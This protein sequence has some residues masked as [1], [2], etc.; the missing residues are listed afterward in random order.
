MSMMIPSTA[1]QMNREMA[2]LP[3]KRNEDNGAWIARAAKAMK[4]AESFVLLMGGVDARAV[5]L[6]VAQARGRAD[7]TPSHFSHVAVLPGHPHAGQPGRTRLYEVPLPGGRALDDAPANNALQMGRLAPYADP[8]AYPNLALIGVP[9]TKAALAKVAARVRMG[10]PH[11]DLCEL[12]LE[13]LAFLWGVGR[14]SNPLLDGK[15]IPSAVA[16]ELLLEHAGVALT[17]N[18]ASQAS[19]PEAIWQAVKWWR[20]EI[21]AETEAAGRPSLPVLTCVDHRLA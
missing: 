9:V 13:W 18:L 6:R 4:G 17:P 16:T 15:G 3:R 11:M 1:T 2:A 14:T 7:L 10:R 8:A 12:V 20:D 5:H 21:C 19:C